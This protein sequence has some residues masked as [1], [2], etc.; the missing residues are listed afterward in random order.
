MTLYLQCSKCGG[1][2]PTIEGAEAHQCP[3]QQTGLMSMMGSKKTYSIVKLV[4]QKTYQEM[5]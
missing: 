1:V 5:K 2:S 4:E 3:A